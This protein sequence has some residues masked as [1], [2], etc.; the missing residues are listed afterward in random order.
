MYAIF[1]FHSI[2]D[3]GSVISYSPRHF[4]L[5][6]GVLAE[7]NIPVLDLDT[8]LEPGTRHGVA[9]TFDD[10]MHS[11]YRQALPVLRDH[12]VPAHLFLATGAV[13]SATPWPPDAV[14]E[15][16]F[17]MLNWDEIG[18]LHAAGVAIECHTR[19]HPDM[20]TLSYEQMQDECEQADDLIGKRLGRRPAYFAYPFGYHNRK[21][22]DYARQR[23]RGAV[24]TE[25][26]LLAAHMDSAALPR[27]DSFYLQSERVIR[28]IDSVWLQGYLAA[29]NILRNVKGS[30]CR[31]DCG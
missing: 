8:L 22:R 10:G 5:L 29:R 2:D 9:L 12:G 1:T 14:D 23:Y 13:D 15:H 4:A 30:Q 31:A 24:T 20:R 16:T 21:V 11:V 18:A 7:K 26:R 3:K 25:L 27:I 19:T 28:A 6:L 17:E